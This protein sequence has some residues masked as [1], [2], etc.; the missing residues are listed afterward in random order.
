[1]QSLAGQWIP[2]A[3]CAGRFYNFINF[4]L[5]PWEAISMSD[6]WQPS[7]DPE[8]AERRTHYRQKLSSAHVE[9]GEN[10]EG[11]VLNVSQSGLAL[12]TKQELAGDE[13]PKMRFQLSESDAWI[14]AKGRVKWR[15][16]AERTAGVEFVDL[17]ATTRKQIEI[18]IFLSYE[19]EFERQ[20]KPT[21]EVEPFEQ[22][23]V[24][25]EST[26]A[27]PFPE[28]WE[29]PGED[30]TVASTETRE[31]WTT[32]E[33]EAQIQ[34]TNLRHPETDTESGTS[35]KDENESCETVDEERKRS[36]VLAEGQFPVEQQTPP[37]VE[38]DQLREVRG[39][40]HRGRLIVLFLAAGLVLLAFVQ[41]R[42]YLQ[43]TKTSEKPPEMTKANPPAP[44]SHATR[45]GEPISAPVSRPEPSVGV[46]NGRTAPSHGVFGLQVGAMAQEENAKA[47]EKSLRQIKV[48][49]IIVKRPG[50]RLFRV[51]AGPYDRVDAAARAKEELE[52][53][54]FKSF[55][56]QWAEENAGA[57]RIR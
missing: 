35:A 43:K 6:T 47:L 53:R 12:R 42:H 3:G 16:A 39:S 25:W 27:I 14:E 1:M 23:D 19:M 10:N 37:T 26:A 34:T 50:D 22:G 28:E 17:P 57:R 5:G 38:C 9:L 24:E 54:G 21:D 29:E 2:I 32:G 44:A 33:P 51:L 4:R 11:V 31:L 46:S 55:R 52:K 13:L 41:V 8:V 20:R 49:A 40:R 30:S 45:G 56:V 7:G 15:N 48:P 36:G 18:L